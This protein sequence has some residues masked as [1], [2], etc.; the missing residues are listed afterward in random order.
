VNDTDIDHLYLCRNINDKKYIVGGIYMPPNPPSTKYELFTDTVE[1]LG[2]KF[3][4]QRFLN[5]FIRRTF[6][7][8]HIYRGIPIFFLSFLD[9]LRLFLNKL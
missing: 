7:D 9:F 8:F 5:F 3:L 6:F 4:D 1:D 2:F